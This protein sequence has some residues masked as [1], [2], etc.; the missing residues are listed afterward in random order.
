MIGLNDIIELLESHNL[1]KVG[2][3]IGIHKTTIWRLKRNR[4]C[5]LETQRKLSEYFLD[6]AENI[7]EKIKKNECNNH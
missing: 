5:G 7:K 4:K 2:A 6:H 1:A 3:R